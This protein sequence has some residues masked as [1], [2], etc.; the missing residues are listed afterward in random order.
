MRR[1]RRPC[2]RG[3][4]ILRRAPDPVPV[5]EY[6]SR[7]ERWTA[8]ISRTD[9]LHLLLS[10]LRLAAFFAGVAVFW[11]AFIHGTINPWWIA[12]P[13]AAFGALAI[14]HARVLQHG[15]RAR[16]ARRIYRRG[17]ERIAGRWARQGRGGARYLARPHLYARDLDLFGEGSL[18]ELLNQART[19]IGEDTLA[20]W[21]LAPA[22]AGE[23][24][25]RQSAVEELR[26]NL[27]LREAIAVLADDAVVGRTGALA[28]WTAAP[29]E[30]LPPALGY[31]YGTAAAGAAALAAA[32]YLGAIG[33]AWLAAWIALEAAIDAVWRRRTSRILHA[34]ETPEH[35]LGLLA[36]LLARVEQEP[37]TSPKLERLHGLLVAGGAPASRR[38]AR[39]RQVVAW[40]DSTHNL[41]FAPFA[42]VLMLKPQLALAVNAWHRAHAAEAAGWLLAIGELEALA[43]LAVHAYEHP[44]DPFPQVAGGDPKFEAVALGHPL[45]A[46]AEVVRNDVAFGGGGPR[47][48]V[49]SGSNMS[50]KSTLLRAV[51]VNAALALAGGTVRA[52]RLAM[53]PLAIG[54]TLRI[55]D[56][57]QEGQSKFYAEILRIRAI[58]G[59]AAGPLPVLFLLDEILHGTNSRDRRLGAEA[60][61]RALVDRGAIGLVTTHDLALTSL[62]ETLEN[63]ASAAEPRGPLAANVH[64]EDWIE[65][66]QLRFD[67][68]MRPG[69]VE[70][71]N[72]LELM[73]AIGLDV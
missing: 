62:A 40:A 39:L 22:A 41:F 11:L 27:D 26:P 19:E 30:A 9:R 63:P 71:S 2:C 64:F 29:P 55:E 54:A 38:I 47:V 68:T 45:I 61:V 65:N 33:G 12:A 52:S 42:Y 13:S 50:G 53:T 32:A 21:L 72:A 25:A 69:V 48:L 56:S 60:I 3:P 43:S 24:A 18:F 49:V 70:R 36:E 44:G 51:G 5:R 46:D 17:L 6:R 8:E 73:R 57:L 35:D 37:F 23:I 7:I 4:A 28:A 20:D 14:G 34:V 58:A 66:G 15:A 31:L 1:S 10:N 59:L 16:R 67:Y